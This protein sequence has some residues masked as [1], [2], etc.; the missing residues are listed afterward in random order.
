MGHMI[1]PGRPHVAH[2]L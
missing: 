1:E 2:R